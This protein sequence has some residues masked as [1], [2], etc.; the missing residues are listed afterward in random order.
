MPG[1]GGDWLVLTSR[2]RR[3]RVLGKAPVVQLAQTPAE[4]PRAPQMS[5]Q[6]AALHSEGRP[7]GLH[8]L[9]SGVWLCRGWYLGT[10]VPKQ[11]ASGMASL[12]HS[13]PTLLSPPGP[14]RNGP[15]LQQ[16]KDKHSLGLA[17]AHTSHDLHLNSEHD[18]TSENT[19]LN[20]SWKL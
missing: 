4:C 2:P 10:P 3:C 13:C 1:D 6:R 14:L 8:C 11:M 12:S 7:E 15:G 17:C 16:V 9:S 20:G 5:P 18:C 19:C